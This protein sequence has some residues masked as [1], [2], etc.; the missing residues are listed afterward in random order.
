MPATEPLN[1]FDFTKMLIYCYDW[2]I[3]LTNTASPNFRRTAI[4]VHVFL[5]RKTRTH[6]LR[7]YTVL[8]KSD[9]KET[10]ALIALRRHPRERPDFGTANSLAS[11]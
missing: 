9:T 2:P 4:R 8:K 11:R 1:T 7:R 3:P 10:D 6:W 5:K